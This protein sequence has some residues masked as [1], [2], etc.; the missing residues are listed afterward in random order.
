MTYIET[1]QSKEILWQPTFKGAVAG[2]EGYRGDL[3][4]TPGD[5]V[6]DKR[7][8]P[9]L[10]AKQVL[11]TVKEGKIVFFT[12]LLPSIANLEEFYA[13]LGADLAEDG[14]FLIYTDDA[15]KK[16]SVAYNGKTF[17]VFQLDESTVWNENLDLAGI[18]K[19]DMKGLSNDEKITM[20]ADELKG[21]K[22]G[23]AAIPFDEAKT[24]VTTVYKQLMGAV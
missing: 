6:G 18:S 20:V 1:L 10:T 17:E 12:G 4:L 24:N 15:A 16:M 19:G 23:G 9:K 14:T 8:P 2:G 21:F 13:L 3:V 7:M 22:T 11:M 5:M